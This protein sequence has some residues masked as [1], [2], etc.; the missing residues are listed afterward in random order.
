M[1]TIYPDHIILGFSGY[2]AL[3]NKKFPS[4]P[5]ILPRNHLDAILELDPYERKCL[6]VIYNMIRNVK[7]ISWD[8]TKMAQEKDL[9]V[10]FSEDM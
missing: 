4:F 5:F 10:K 6:S 3:P 2:V 8:K 7:P 1:T 9:G